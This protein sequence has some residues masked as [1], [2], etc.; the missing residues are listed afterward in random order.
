MKSRDSKL[1]VPASPLFDEV[2]GPSEAGRVPSIAPATRFSGESETVGR[3][4]DD[5]IFALEQKVFSQ[6]DV[7]LVLQGD[8]VSL[9]YIYD[10]LTIYPN[11]EV[12]KDKLFSALDKCKELKLESRFKSLWNTVYNMGQR[13]TIHKKFIKQLK[14]RTQLKPER[15]VNRGDDDHGFYH[16]DFLN[17][18]RVHYH[19]KFHRALS[20][21]QFGEMVKIFVEQELVSQEQGEAYIAEVKNRNARARATLDQV[22]SVSAKDKMLRQQSHKRVLLSLIA[23]CNN[24]DVLVHVHNYLLEPKFDY[25]RAIPKGEVHP[26]LGKQW[27]GTDR[28]GKVV[29]TSETWAKLEKGFSLQIIRNLQNQTSLFSPELGLERSRQLAVSH[30]FFGIKRS[31]YTKNPSAERTYK[32]Q[33]AF[34]AADVDLLARKYRK[35]FSA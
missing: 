30:G 6:P 29:K 33:E 20:E 31:S 3:Q 17:A 16:Q 15:Y 25:L 26:T 2:M 28:E 34:A 5:P 11:A 24:N 1:R 18:Q 22:L 27:Q 9:S 35:V 12:E 8:K 32:T 14:N 4:A 23:G 10:A 13:E 19:I 7:A 21:E